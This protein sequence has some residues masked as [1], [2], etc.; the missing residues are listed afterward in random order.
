MGT[1]TPYDKA[2]NYIRAL[3]TPD[4]MTLDEAIDFYGE[5]IEE[6]SEAKALMSMDL[7]KERGENDDD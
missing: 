4:K 1:R 5:L 6:L 7:V 3:C 2:I